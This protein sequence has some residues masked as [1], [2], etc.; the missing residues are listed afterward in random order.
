M[1]KKTQ[2]KHAASV[3]REFIISSIEEV[4]K[5]QCDARNMREIVYSTRKIGDITSIMLTTTAAAWD[6]DV[7]T[8]PGTQPSS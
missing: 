3:T 5:I 1:Q 4:P 8:A 6:V 7:C 2:G